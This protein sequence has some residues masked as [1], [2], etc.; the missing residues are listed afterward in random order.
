MFYEDVLPMRL[1]GNRAGTGEVA[2]TPLVER[3]GFLGDY[4]T[5]AFEKQGER[6]APNHPTAWLPTQRVAA[7]WQAMVTDK[8]FAE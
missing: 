3:A 1:T 6:D 5:K 7:A 8:P 2:L 4:Q